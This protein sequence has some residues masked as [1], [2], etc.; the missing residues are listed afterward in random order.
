MEILYFPHIKITVDWHMRKIISHF[1]SFCAFGFAE[2]TISNKGQPRCYCT[3]QLLA[4]PRE[5]IK[6]VSLDHASAG[7]VRRS[8]FLCGRAGQ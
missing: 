5:A 6:Q 3:S 7:V 1:L 4:A 8:F 2:H